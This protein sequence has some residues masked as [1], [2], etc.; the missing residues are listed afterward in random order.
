MKERNAFKLN[1]ENELIR[2]QQ[3]LDYNNSE[4]TLYNY[5]ST[6]WE[7]E[8]IEISEAHSLIFRSKIKNKITS[9]NLIVN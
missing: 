1:L 3:Q 6:K 2:R 4:T 9:I 7:L 8:Q 5:N